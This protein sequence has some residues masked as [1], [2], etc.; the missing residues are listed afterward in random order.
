MVCLD[1]LRTVAVGATIFLSLLREDEQRA[2]V[3]QMEEMRRGRF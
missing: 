2:L 1:D 3:R